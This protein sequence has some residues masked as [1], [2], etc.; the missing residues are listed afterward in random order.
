MRLYSLARAIDRL[1]VYYAVI[2][3]AFFV[4]LS[5]RSGVSPTQFLIFVLLLPVIFYF[6]HAFWKYI[7]GIASKKR[8]GWAFSWKHFFL[9]D[10][11][12]FLLSIFLFSIAVSIAFVRVTGSFFHTLQ[13]EA[14]QTPQT[15]SAKTSLQPPAEETP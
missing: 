4:F 10:S 15:T 14:I 8:G 1:F 6:S 2:F 11:A 5:F 7:Y 9:Q 13:V 3:L 12:L